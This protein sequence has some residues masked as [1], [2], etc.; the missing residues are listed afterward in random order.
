MRATLDVKTNGKGA[1]L[2]RQALKEYKV[3][4]RYRRRMLDEAASAE[5]LYDVLNI[6]TF[7][8]NTPEYE[9]SP[10]RIRLFQSTAG[11]INEHSRTCEHC[12][13]ALVS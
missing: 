7:H 2:M 8:A 11:W 6:L 3:P 9:G 1:Q 4:E 5:T 13:S 12:M 10:E